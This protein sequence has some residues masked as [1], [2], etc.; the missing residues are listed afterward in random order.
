M[1]EDVIIAER[2]SLDGTKLL[3][4]YRSVCDAGNPRKDDDNLAT[5]YCKNPVLGDSY[6]RPDLDTNSERM[7]EIENVAVAKLPLYINPQGGISLTTRPLDHRNRNSGLVG[8]AY[9]THESIEEIGVHE[10]T[11]N[12]LEY[13]IQTEVDKYNLFLSGLVYD[14]SLFESDVCDQG[15]PHLTETTRKYGFLGDT[16]IE[17]IYA[18]VGADDWVV[19][20]PQ[21]LSKQTFREVKAEVSMGLN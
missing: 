16:G 21:K 15:H 13:E 7:A 12:E 19:K 14:Y 10:L 9:I 6:E 4:I 20:K 3:R 5:L 17:E 11:Q 18:D 2:H 1:N 8:M